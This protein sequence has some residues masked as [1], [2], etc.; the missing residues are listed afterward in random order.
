MPVQAV[1]WLAANPQRGNMFN[2]FTW[3]G[4]ILYRM[5]PDERVFIDGQT[6]FYGEALSREYLDVVSANA[7]WQAILERYRVEWMLISVQDP[8]AVKLSGEQAG[9]SVLYS[10]ETSVVFRRISSLP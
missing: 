5:W 6:D 2:E 1:D 4:Y 10:D 3:G 9:W 7:G 8:L